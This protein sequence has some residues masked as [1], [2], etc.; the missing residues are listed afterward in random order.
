MSVLTGCASPDRGADRDAVV[1]AFYPLAFAASQVGAGPVVDVTPP[2]AEPHDVE[3]SAGDIEQIRAARLVVYL[4]HGFQPA[5]ERAVARREGRSLDVLAGSSVLPGQAGG[6]D[7]HIWLDPI[8]L[9][10]IA[11]TIAATLGDVAS[12]DA[13]ARRLRALDRAYQNGLRT[14]VRREVV[15]SHA[16]FGYLAARYHLVQ[17]PLTGLAPETEPTARDIVRLVDE[18]RRTG[19]TTVFTEP[20]V[21]GDLAATVAREA[22]VATAVLDPVESIRRDQADAGADYFTLMRAN[23]AGLRKALGCR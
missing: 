10:R 6:T 17:V 12:A 9:A 4:G 3:L 16:A 14:C 22:D 8:R 13:L 21:S 2:G 18:V 20:L 1:A 11:R 15:T 7:L 19:A 23:L 5:L